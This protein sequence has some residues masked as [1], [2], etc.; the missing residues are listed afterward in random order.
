MQMIFNPGGTGPNK[1]DDIDTN[2]VAP[3]PWANLFAM[4][5]KIL[6]AFLSGG[7]SNDG[8]D[9]VDNGSSPMQVHLHIVTVS[10]QHVL[11]DDKTIRTSAHKQE[12][13]K[14]F[15]V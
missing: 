1:S 2:S 10:S 8:I 4:G 15:I 6:T 5:L 3:S 14:D 7:A 13:M 9:K 12:L 11:N